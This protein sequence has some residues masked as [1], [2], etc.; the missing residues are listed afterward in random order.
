MAAESASSR[1]DADAEAFFEKDPSASRP[2]AGL[3][4]SF[5]ELNLSR[6]LLQAVSAMGYQRPTPVQARA[7]PLALA[8]R[9]VCAS[10]QTGSGKTAAFLLPCLERLLYRSRGGGGA[11]RVLVVSPTRELATQIHAECLKLCARTD[12]R[13]ALVVG[14]LALGPQTAAL[15]A[16][17]EIVVGTP[18]RLV[19]HL[20]NSASVHLDDVECLV[21][22]EADRLLD[23]GFEE[24]VHELVKF[25]PRGRQTML[26]SATMGRGVAQLIKLSLNRPVRVCVDDVDGVA[27]RL[28]QEFVRVRAS[29]EPQR[30]AITVSLVARSFRRNAIV[31]CGSKKAAHRLTIVL[32]LLGI[33]ACELHGNLTQAQRAEA[34]SRFRRGKASILVATDLAGRGLDIPRVDTVIN[35]HMPREHSRYVHRVGR[36]ARAGRRGRAVS[37]VGEKGRAVMKAAVRAAQSKGAIDLVRSRTVPPATITMWRRRIDAVEGEV[38]AVLELERAEKCMRVAEMEANK[39]QNLMVHAEDIARRPKRT[40]FQSAKSKEATKAASLEA[41]ENGGR[42]PTRR[43]KVDA[44]EEARTA[45]AKLGP[46]EKELLKL[47]KGPKRDGK[48]D[49]YKSKGMGMHRLTRTKRRRRALD[50]AMD[51]GEEAKMMGKQASQVRQARKARDKGEAPA[52]VNIAN[53]EKRKKAKAKAAAKYHKEKVA[54]ESAD[55]KKARAERLKGTGESVVTTATKRKAA[56]KRK[57]AKGGFKSK[58]RFK[59]R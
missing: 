38:E 51:D 24:E 37:L 40:W 48:R 20:R 52:A 15:R 36:T 57:L 46:A 33:K 14:G 29:A 25:C 43:E 42:A 6:P 3:A 30:E 56:K 1:A 44:R 54:T 34:L 26:F 9:D 8:G 7:I 2:D 55:A 11:T 17:P 58:K 18:G 45:F 31:F 47:S 39:A 35:M 19:D 21:L 23:M 49:G 53:R 28:I 16:R 13:A 10:A 41:Y 22:D 4:A 32:G 12:I 5:V 27:D 59:R 50:A